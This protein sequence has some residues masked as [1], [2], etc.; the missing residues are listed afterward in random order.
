MKWLEKERTKVEEEIGKIGLKKED[1]YD[2][3]RWQKGMKAVALRCE[4]DLATC[5]HSDH[6]GRNMK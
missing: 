1:A 2:R 4:V 5:A 6:T 3:T